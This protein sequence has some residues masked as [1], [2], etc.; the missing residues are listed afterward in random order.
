LTN[1]A[2]NNEISIPSIFALY[3]SIQC[4]KCCK[5]KELKELNCAKKS[6]I[7]IPSLFACSGNTCTIQFHVVNVVNELKI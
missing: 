6:E 7:S 3:N 1:C 5:F 2:K 4:C